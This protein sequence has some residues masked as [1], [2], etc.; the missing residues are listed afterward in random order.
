MRHSGLSSYRQRLIGSTAY[1]REMKHPIYS[2]MGHTLPFRF[3]TYIRMHK[4]T[5]TTFKTAPRSSQLVTVPPPQKKKLVCHT[6]PL[7]STPHHTTPHHSTSHHTTPLHITPLHTTPLH[8]T[9]LNITPHHSTPLHYT[10]HHTTPLHITPLHTTPHHTTPLHSTSHHSTPHHSTPHMQS[11]YSW[12]TFLH[13][14]L[15]NIKN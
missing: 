2:P 4:F 10:P 8:T 3:F 13:Y 7:H 12:I 14:S 5:H 6:T 9:P 1:D 11:L 15:T